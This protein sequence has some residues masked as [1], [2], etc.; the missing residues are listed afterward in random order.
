MVEQFRGLGVE[1]GGVL[2]VHTSYRAVRPVPGGPAGL[3][4]ALRHAL[5]SN[6]TLV[7]PSWGGDDDAPFDP[8]ATPVTPD[9]GVVADTFWR[10]PGVV[11]SA[12]FFAFA[13]AGPEARRITA[14]PLPLP[15]HNPSSPVGRVHEL[16]G[17]VLLLGIGHDANTTLHLSELLAGVPYRVPR[18][19]TVLGEDGRPLRV[20]YGENDHCCQ[21]FALA[22][23]WLRARG[24]QRE[25]QVGH[26]N[27][28]LMRSRDVVT[29]G[30]EQLA[31]DPLIFL[32]PAGS[33][34]AE[35]DEARRS[36]ST[37]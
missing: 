26:A 17:Q 23:E 22:D 8:T 28:R 32:H 11:R 6:G 12:Q 16:D 31:R 15:P 20:D 14:D 24:L 35:C 27:A 30:R 21:R 33:G 5:G 25:G 7:M 29:V 3:I 36:V 10:L 2:L 1:E 4:A 18:H 19:C 13:A 37:A 34:C 9:L